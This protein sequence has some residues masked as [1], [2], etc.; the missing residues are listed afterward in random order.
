MR[1][2]SKRRRRLLIERERLKKLAYP[3]PCPR[4]HREPAEEFHEV[5]NRSQNAPGAADVELMVPLGPDCHRWVTTHPT[6]AHDEGWTV[7][8]YELHDAEVIR[9]AAWQ[10]LEQSLG[11][12][13]SVYTYPLN[14]VTYPPM[15]RPPTGRIVVTTRLD[16][17]LAAW[18]DEQARIRSIDR[19]ECLRRLVAAARE[20]GEKTT[21]TGRPRGPQ[22][23]GG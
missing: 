16:S 5:V 21:M 20:V 3:E 4:C 7:Y 9:A 15:P 14:A 6:L 17:D 11:A 12:G 22:P 18:L 19:S 23:K 13:V 1:P 10:R 2:V 8:S